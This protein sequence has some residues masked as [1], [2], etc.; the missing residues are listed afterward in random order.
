MKLKIKKLHQDAIV[1]KYATAGA[2][3]FDLNAINVKIPTPVNTGG[4]ITFDTGLAFEIPE[5]WVMMIFSRSGSGFGKDTRLAN[6]VGIIDSDYRGQVRVKITRDP[7]NSEILVVSNGDRIAQAM[8]IPVS[9]V[10]FDLVEELSSTER[11]A[12]G[13]GST[14]K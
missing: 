14:G 12:G 7:S 10:E 3:C 9:Q 1:P 2:A 5:G 4:P 6:C 13:F 8:L 11:G